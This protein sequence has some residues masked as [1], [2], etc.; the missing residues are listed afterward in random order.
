MNLTFSVSKPLTTTTRQIKY[1]QTHNFLQHNK[2]YSTYCKN[3]SKEPS[4]WQSEHLKSLTYSPAYPVKKT[5]VSM[6]TPCL[7]ITKPL[8][9]TSERTLGEF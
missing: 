2:D 5:T 3:V 7:C 1:T 6:W 8:K 4:T 9:F